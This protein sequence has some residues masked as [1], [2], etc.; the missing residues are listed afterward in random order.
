MNI[1]EL[2][3]KLSQ[4]DPSLIVIRPGDVKIELVY[5]ETVHGID[6]E[7]DYEVVILD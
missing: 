4:F 2:I 3:E 7:D 6:Q 5:V 1:K